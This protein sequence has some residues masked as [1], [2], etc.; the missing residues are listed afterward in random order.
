MDSRVARVGVVVIGRNEGARL[1]SCLTSLGEHAGDLVYVDSGSTDGSQELVRA[2]GLRLVELDVSIPFT[3]ARA[4]HTGYLALSSAVPDIE[5]VQFVDGDCEVQP[6]WIATGTGF[7][8]QNESVAAVC[9]RRRERFAD[10]SIYN[11]F[12][13]REW[14]TP[15][16]E[17]DACGG[18]SLMRCSAYDEA[19][20]FD[21]RLI[22]GE[23]PELCVRLRE[24][25]WKIWRLDA[26]MTLHDAAMTRFSQWWQRSVRTGY[27]F[28]EVSRLHRESRF[29]IWKTETN[30]A[31]VWAGIVP[32]AICIGALAHP[33]ALALLAVYPLQ[34]AR[35]ALCDSSS[36]PGKWSR[37]AYLV[38]GKFA[39]LQGVLRFHTHRLLGRR[40]T[41]IEYK[42]TD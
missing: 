27:G 3:A 20:G 39:E 30:R 6:N 33:I 2:R 34:I 23:E 25:G 21:G 17:A 19:G 32:I 18:D 40:S 13:D 38:L 42:S 12:C 24:L 37:A 26:E 31:I 16:G 41:L 1:V 5:F 10:A 29:A 11:Q 35:I 8:K 14:D 9:G 22:C 4:R 28:A 15:V 36:S 7:L